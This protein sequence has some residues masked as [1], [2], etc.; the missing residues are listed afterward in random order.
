[1]IAE[2]GAPKLYSYWAILALDIFL[3]IFWLCAFAILAA[4]VSYIFILAED[5]MYLDSTGVMLAWAS[6]QA[7]A[8][9]LGGAQWQVYRPFGQVRWC[10]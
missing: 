8:A 5:A 4:E 7:A 9:G 6:C 10:C 2:Y 3:V 1:M